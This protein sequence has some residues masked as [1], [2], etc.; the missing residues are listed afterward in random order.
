MNIL[1]GANG[2]LGTVEEYV[3]K[4]YQ[5]RRTVHWHMLFWIKPG[6][7]PEGTVM[8]E[9]P[10]C[11]DTSNQVA[12]YLRKIVKKMLWH[13]RCYPDR[14]FKGSFGKVLSYCTYGFP[15]STPQ[16]AEELDSDEVRYLYIRRHE[17][18][19]LV[20]PY[21]PELPIL[22]GASHNIQRVSKHGF[23]QYLPKYISKPE[24]SFSIN[25][26]ENAS[27][28]QRYLQTRVIGAVEALE[29]FMGFHQHQMT[30]QTMFLPTELIAKQR[31][32]KT[33]GQLQSLEADSE[34]MY[35][36]TRF[37]TYLQRPPELEEITYPDFYKCFRRA[38]SEEQR[39]AE[40][41]TANESVA[42]QK[43]KR[44]DD[45]SDYIARKVVKDRATAELTSRLKSTDVPDSVHLL[46]L[47]HCMRYENVPCHV[48]QALIQYFGASGIDTN[49]I[50]VHKLASPS[51]HLPVPWFRQRIEIPG[52]SYTILR[53]QFPLLLAYAVT[54]HRVQ[55]LTDQKMVVQLNAKFF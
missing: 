27:E 7:E 11:A 15:F 10:R 13:G 33:S 30:H 55:G 53:Q 28:P 18:D 1:T 5:K 54:V 22:W 8:A 44:A 25:L 47:I 9:L 41:M 49:C 43:T 19:S 24:P 32:L 20:V 46:A 39:K 4:E 12:A 34:D 35:I 42:S 29:V 52:V 37:E 50:V 31:M 36:G 14:C 48:Q 17:E 45:F 51:E 6:T 23:E 3:W 26:P 2:P 21:N 16:L 40:R 38:T